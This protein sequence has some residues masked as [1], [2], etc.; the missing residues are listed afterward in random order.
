MINFFNLIVMFYITNLTN[1]CKLIDNTPPTFKKVEIKK[2]NLKEI[3][4]TFSED[5][6]D[7][8][9]VT[10]SD[11]W[12]SGTI[13]PAG[14][15]EKVEIRKGN[16]ILILQ[17]EISKN[18][19]LEEIN[20][21]KETPLFLGTP[22]QCIRDWA[23]NLV[24]TFKVLLTKDNFDT[25]EFPPI[26]QSAEIKDYQGKQK[27]TIT[28][29]DDLDNNAIDSNNFEIKS[30]SNENIQLNVIEI[31]SPQDNNIIIELPGRSVKEKEKI[32]VF[33]T[34]S[35]NN[36]K[37]IKGKNGESVKDFEEENVINNMD[38]TGPLFENAVINYQVGNK[39]IVTFNE[40]IS[41][42]NPSLDNWLLNQEPEK[43]S[44]IILVNNKIELTLKNNVEENGVYTISYIHNDGDEGNIKDITG[45]FLKTFNEKTIINKYDKTPP[46][47]LNAKIY[48]SN[49]NIIIVEFN[50][51]VVLNTVNWLAQK[52]WTVRINQGWR[53]TTTWPGVPPQLTPNTFIELILDSVYVDDIKEFKD[54]KVNYSK[55]EDFDYIEDKAGNIIQKN[56]ELDVEFVDDTQ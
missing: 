45:N 11:W 2:G 46:E 38:W 25:P 15:P 39:I 8:E 26:F 5:I 43:F 4:I 41:N 50:E 13:R 12:V 27:I 6:S 51:E 48:F 53:V 14:R 31:D 19:I 16:V 35:E 40:N 37:N 33:Y 30:E 47:P 32:S 1:A 20:Y 24:E 55:R 56:Y 17:N 52:T 42:D 23:G 9:H 34:E 22:K 10:K 18:S 54:V 3:I 21:Y 36:E 7:N 28:F 49:P 44:N 29:D